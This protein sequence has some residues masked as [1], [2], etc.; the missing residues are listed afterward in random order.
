MSD[1]NALINLDGISDVAIKLLDMI[2]HFA[3]WAV[4]PKGKAADFEEGLVLY[5]KSIEQDTT[6]TDQEKAVNISLSR[7]AFRKY[8]NQAKIVLKAVENLSQ[9]P[10]S[11]HIDEIDADWINT[12]LSYA[13]NISNEEMQMIW[14]KLLAEKVNGN[15]DINKKMLQIFSCIEREDIEVFY[16]LCSMSFVHMNR[17]GSYYPF[18][19]IKLFPGFY[20]SLGIRRYHLASLDNLGLIEYDIHGGFVLPQNIPPLKY[21]DYKIILNS[22][23]RINNGNVR[24]TRSGRALFSITRAIPQNDFLSFCKKVWTHENIEYNIVEL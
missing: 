3:G 8:T 12:F 19:Y 18:I 10:D 6:L 22:S 1:N 17:K 13:E 14:G 2:E 16:K 23:K 5:K 24:F 9:S 15:S 7:T 20:K 4:S 11:S 21:D